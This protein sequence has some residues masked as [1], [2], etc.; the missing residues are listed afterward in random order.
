M[1]VGV[2]VGRDSNLI[3]KEKI[4]I[5]APLLFGAFAVCDKGNS[6]TR[7][8]SIFWNCFSC[9]LVQ[10]DVKICNYFFVNLKFICNV[11][12]KSFPV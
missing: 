8:F 5:S 6:D 12:L 2:L 9:V 10:A 3:N 7:S 4:Q 11:L 1:N